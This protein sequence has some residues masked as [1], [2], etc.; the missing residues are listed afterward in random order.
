VKPA[1][2]EV[3]WPRPS[4]E[5]VKAIRQFWEFVHG[6]LDPFWFKLAG[7]R[8]EPCHFE[9]DSLKLGAAQGD[10]RLIVR[11]RGMRA[12]KQGE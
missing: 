5:R 7:T 3:E 1:V 6:H 2:I 12:A 8:Y 9:A 4:A 10:H 11:L